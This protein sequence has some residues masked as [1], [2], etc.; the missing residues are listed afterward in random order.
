LHAQRDADGARAMNEPVVLGAILR[1]DL[2]GWTGA[3]PSLPGAPLRVEEN[4]SGVSS[5][6]YDL[7]PQRALAPVSQAAERIGMTVASLLDRWPFDELPFPARCVLELGV[8]VDDPA[9][10]WS[11]V[12]PAAFLGALGAVDIELC[13]SVYPSTNEDQA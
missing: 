2:R 10:P 9:S 4:A 13:L 3:A 8:A 12:W 11:V 1:V 6:F 7:L 5:F